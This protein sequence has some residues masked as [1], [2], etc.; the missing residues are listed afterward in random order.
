[1][2]TL[3]KRYTLQLATENDNEAIRQLYEAD[4][5]DGDIQVQFLR[6]PDVF[7][8][9]KSEGEKLVLMLLR[10]TQNENQAVAMGTCI[11]RKEF[12]NRT[13]KR[14]GYLTGLKILPAYRKKILFIPAL[15]A[16]LN[17][18]TRNDVDVYYTTILKSNL[19]AQRILEKRHTGMPTY[20]YHNDYTVYLFSPKHSNNAA[21]TLQRGLTAELKKFY[22]EQLPAFDFTPSGIEMYNIPEDIFFSLHDKTGSIV[23][24]CAIWN[25]QKSK[26]YRVA[27]YK[28]IYRIIPYLPSKL[29][30]YPRFPRPDS[31]CNYL[32]FAFVRAKDND[33]GIAEILIRKVSR[34]FPQSDFL[35]L[36]L[37][38]SSPFNKV[39]K[40]IKHIKYQ[41]RFYTVSWNAED[42]YKQH[43]DISIGL[44]VGLL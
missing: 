34:Q 18:Q 16:F 19:I 37:H 10:D 44:E 23:A 15:Y 33:P 31:T 1:M 39:F 9:L 6:N 2:N 43:P 30:G 41:S 7:G 29:L 3:N 42:H 20:H 28:G 5:F 36:G 21:C 8:S 14:V 22:Q 24:A 4:D 32:T 38:D 27:G 12:I 40:H 26:Q 13:E 11:I 25:Q 35:M 17:E